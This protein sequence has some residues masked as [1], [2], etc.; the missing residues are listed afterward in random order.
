[1]HFEDYDTMDRNALARGI[2]SWRAFEERS[3]HI[4]RYW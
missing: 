3:T 2:D 4:I 1:M